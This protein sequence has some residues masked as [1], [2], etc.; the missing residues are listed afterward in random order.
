VKTSRTSSLL[1]RSGLRILGLPS[2]DVPGPSDDGVLA[3]LQRRALLGDVLFHGSGRDD[4][5]V[6]EPIRRSRD[7]TEFGDQEAVYATTDPVWAMYFAL[8]RRGQ[9]FSTRNVS[10]GIAAGEL[11]PRW[12]FFSLRGGYHDEPFEDGWVYLLPRE[13]FIPEPP[14]AGKLDTAQWVSSSAVRPVGRIAVKPSDFP[15]RDLLVKHR[16]R[17]PMLVTSLRAGLRTRIGPKRRAGPPHPQ[18]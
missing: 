14:L 11:Y 2:I 3:S 12:Y 6:L 7:D 9:P 15:F 17:E 5:N 8:L 1:V 16:E 10:I 4:L 13:G 18:G